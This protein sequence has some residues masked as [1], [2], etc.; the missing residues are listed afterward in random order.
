[1]GSE[2]LSSGAAD[3]GEAEMR[4]GGAALAGA[5]GSSLSVLFSGGEMGAVAGFSGANGSSAAGGNA[6]GAIGSVG[7]T[8]DGVAGDFST[9]A[10]GAG[11]EFSGSSGVGRAAEGIGTEGFASAASAGFGG[12]TSEFPAATGPGNSVGA[13]VAGF[14]DG[15]CSGCMTSCNVGGNISTA[16]GGSA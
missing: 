15:D 16:V 7:F 6:G 4:V 12:P 13:G 1:S 5:K 10:N 14:T 3:V 9:G 2:N 8:T 11:S